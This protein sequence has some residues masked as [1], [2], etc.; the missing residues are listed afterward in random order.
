[1]KSFKSPLSIYVIWHPS[2][3][4]GIKYAESIYNTYS[5]ENDFVT[6][7]RYDI[8]VSYRT[9]S[10][11]KDI[12]API[13]FS[14]S[15]KNALIILVDE[16]MFNDEDWTIGLNK[17]LKSKPKN[18]RVFPISFSKY[19]FDLN[20]EF[21]SS[22]QFIKTKQQSP[23]FGN[24]FASNNKIIKY[25]LLESI[26]KFLFNV[27]ENYNTKTDSDAPIKLFIS[28][29]K[30][31][32][33]K[34]A[35]DFRNYI[36]GNTKLKAF[37]DANDIADGH[38]FEQEIKKNIDHSAFIIF[39]TDE[40][41]N[42]EWCRKEVIIAKRYR[43]PIIAVMDIKKGERRSFPYSGNF[44]TI[45]WDDNFEEV[46]NLILSQIIS[47]KYNELFLK[48]I[49]TMYKLEEKYSCIILP[50][51]PEL[52]NYIDIERFKE[53]RKEVKPFI[54]L[55]PDPPI[56][57]EELNLLNDIDSEIKFITPLMLPTYTT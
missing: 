45:I 35:I 30:A 51:A 17:L 48:S 32:G 55:Y 41:A 27:K 25:R 53:E 54:I 24:D 38:Y 12:F 1:M 31:D 9:L 8:P 37:F 6:H 14:E 28:H 52:F 40:Y 4:E 16:F 42:R 56:G 49:V 23:D 20:K 7:A 21:L 47:D 18:T 57:I 13:P 10:Y 22:T 44:P 3:K 39:N 2:F 36:Y 34:L 33:E 5:G 15:D 19:A 11:G 46:I 29:A 43:C 26:A 50:K